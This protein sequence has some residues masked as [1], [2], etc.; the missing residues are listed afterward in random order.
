MMQQT[1]FYKIVQII[2]GYCLNLS[3]FTHI[4]RAV[5]LKQIFSIQRIGCVCDELRLL[6]VQP[7]D[8]YLLFRDTNAFF[9]MFVNSS[10][11][12]H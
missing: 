4:N 3:R 6:F 10:Q 8:I 2:F 11:D 12:F 1:L 7:M 9:C 5:K